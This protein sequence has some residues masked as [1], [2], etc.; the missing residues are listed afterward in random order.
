MKNKLIQ[1]AKNNELK[2]AVASQPD[3]IKTNGVWVPNTF[4]KILHDS[5]GRVEMMVTELTDA[6]LLYSAG[7][8]YVYQGRGGIKVHETP[9]GVRKQ[10]QKIAEKYGLNIIV[11]DGVLYEND[12]I[13]VKTDG[14]IDEVE[15]VKDQQTMVKGGHIIA[16]YA[17][18]TVFKNSSEIVAKKIFIIP[19]NEY[20][21]ILSAGTKSSYPTMMAQKSVMKRVAG[22][23]YSLLGVAIEKEEHNIDEMEERLTDRETLV[24]AKVQKDTFEDEKKEVKA[25]DTEVDFDSI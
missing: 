5:F 13:T 16:P 17:V 9:K 21:A 4:F 14:R 25:D 8:F 18:V 24:D 2:L 6:G 12:R 20:M 7:D 15:I 3:N 19:Q 23:I 22:G 11:S 10:L 1:M